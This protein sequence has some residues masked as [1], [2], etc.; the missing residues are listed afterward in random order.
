MIA[1]AQPSWANQ[2]N[3]EIEPQSADPEVATE[4]QSLQ[5][6]SDI[7]Q[8]SELEQPA[9]TADQWL[10]QIAQA[11][12]IEI[13]EMRVNAT[14]TGLE[15][16]LATTGALPTPS[17]QVIGNALIADIP[18]AV[19]VLPD[20]KE[21]QQAN[22]TEGIALISVTP[23]GDG[24]RVAITGT[25]APPTVDVRTE[26]QGLILSVVPGAEAAETNDDAIQVV[27]TATRT[28]EDVQSVPR[29]VTII[30][31]E[32][33][34]EQARVSRS[35]QDILGNLVPGFSPPS[36]TVLLNSGQ[37]LRG[38]FPQVLID[39]VPIISNNF[40][41]QARDLR[42][43]D[44]AAIER[45]EIVR[46]ATA[47]YGNGGTGGVI[48][49]ITRRPSET[50]IIS[51]V[52]FGV[53][54]PGRGDDVTLPGEGFGNFFQAGFAGTEGDINFNFSIARNDIGT[55]YDA[56][57]NPL[58]YGQSTL[59]DSV[60]LNLL[61]GLGVNIGETQQ[62]QLTA[63]Y[64]NADDNSNLISDPSILDIPGIQAARGIAVPEANYIEAPNPGN[65]NTIISLTY[66]HEA[67]LGSQ[68]QAQA[69]YRSSGFRGEYFDGRPF[70]F[71][72]PEVVQFVY[73]RELF[74]G[75]LQI[76]TPLSSALSL[77]WGADYSSER[78][79]QPTNVFDTAVFDSSGKRT[80]QV[81]DEIPFAY[82]VN[83]FGAFAQMQWDLSPQWIL[84][85][86]ARYEQ[87]G[88]SVEDYTIENFGFEP[89]RQ[90]EGGSLSF[91]DVVFNAGL[92]Y[93]ATDTINLFANFAQ[94]F[95]AP[96]YSRALGQVPNSVEA[97]LDITSPQKV[98]SYELG[99][100]GNWQTLQF[101]LAGFYTDSD[102]GLRIVPGEAGRSATLAREPQ[103]IYGLEAALD[104]Q[105]GGGWGLGGT[106]TWTEGEFKNAEG[107]FVALSSLAIS[108]FKL[109]TYV[110]HETAFGWRNRLQ[111]IFVGNR[112]GGFEDKT[113]PVPI[114]SY[115]TLDFISSIPLFGG[116]LNFSVENLL[117][118]Q[119]STVV[120]QYFSGFDETGNVAARGRM[121]RLGYSINF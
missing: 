54:A 97:D 91:D 19:L 90:V 80:L 84:S 62:L 65:D 10:T 64:F 118:E 69:Y 98:N 2:N 17:T 60:E 3:A 56:A 43:I 99:V 111:A 71:K 61:G 49:I 110:Q 38:R 112:D 115:I 37:N 77:L 13:T 23:R 102:L 24:I 30:E 81:V 55:A 121:F 73:E 105:P 16:V 20:G 39:G 78:V 12:I 93:Q 15:L 117:N 85:G 119:Y 42:S 96:D 36:Q 67:L 107:E 18:N 66:T 50:G 52:E 100:R 35:L 75:R 46:G 5:T 47:T 63:N 9:I 22:P 57:G 76:D 14:D 120:S 108:P 28:E 88:L 95:S 72:D 68:L 7:S 40:S 114:G 25:E 29:S 45:I 113:D 26:A 82:R 32:E 33:I 79:N 89:D 86:G 109:T 59:T 48:N 104:W 94:G 101:S 31:R 92:V 6:S 74:G 53:N 58:P 106:T 34:A 70:E 51:T 41:S 103:R 44:P 1:I 87:F 27:V 11:A 116:H 21:F 4:S 83:N 8:L